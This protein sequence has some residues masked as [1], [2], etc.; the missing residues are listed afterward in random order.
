MTYPPCIADESVSAPR[1]A[2]GIARMNDDLATERKSLSPCRQH[3]D[4]FPLPGTASRT[5][6][7][8]RSPG[9]A[10]EACRWNCTG[11]GTARHGLCITRCPG[12][13]SVHRCPCIRG[14]QGARRVSML[15]TVQGDRFRVF[16][17]AAGAI[18]KLSARVPDRQ[19]SMRACIGES[20]RF[21]SI[22]SIISCIIPEFGNTLSINSRHTE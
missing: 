2:P 20:T 7:I 13:R 4:L 22:F 3:R 16:R 9:V 1:I 14:A 5:L 6:S 17:P 11:A 15:R 18:R 10:A 21:F 12:Q 8:H 19:G